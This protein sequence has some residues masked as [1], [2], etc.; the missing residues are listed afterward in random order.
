M[1]GRLDSSARSF[2]ESAAIYEQSR[3]GWP[4]EAVDHAIRELDLSPISTV[5]DLA[6]GTGKLTRMLVDRFHRVIAVEPLAEMRAL[7][8]ANVPKADALP[9]HAEQ[10]PLGEGSIDSAF[11]GEAFHWFDGAPALSQIGRV[12]RPGGGLVLMWNVPAKPTEPSIAAASELLQQRGAK[13]RA[14]NR[15][16]SGEWRE[17]FAQSRFEELREAQFEHTQ[18]VDREQLLAFFESMS[19]IA[20]LPK[21]ERAE[22]LADVRRVLDA[23][24]YTRF[25]RT[26]LFVT[27]LGSP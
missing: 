13:D 15:Y 20:V 1:S 7:L 6:A 22:L 16:D 27:R 11:I 23:D 17:P 26:E 3:P 18:S 2:N 10:I 12:L 5:L 14:I 25:W 4:S 9:G 24:R 21:D 19:W 8:E